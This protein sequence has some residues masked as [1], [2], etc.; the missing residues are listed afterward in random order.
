MT[1]SFFLFILALPFAAFA[2]GSD[3]QVEATI[4][5]HIANFNYEEPGVMTEKGNLFGS[6][7]QLLWNIQ[8]TFAM[9]VG[10]H[11]LFGNLTY[12][13]STFSG[14]PVT[15]ETEDW[16]L[17][18]QLLAHFRQPNFEVAF[19]VAR[20]VWF[21]DLVI[22]Y[23]RTTTYTYFPVI[24]KGKLDRFYTSLEYRIWGQGRNVSTLSDV[25]T[26]RSDVELTQDNGMGYA[27]EVGYEIPREKVSFRIFFAYDYWSVADSNVQ[28]DGVDFLF[29]P[30]NNTQTY[31]L[32]GG[33][34]F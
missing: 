13:G 33:I 10:G 31:L 27:I 18:G 5:W 23:T 17:Q 7:G 24:F 2:L 14:T 12:D 22:S 26:A 8:P 20:R 32:G 25:S 16:V 30:E 3:N 1:K 9:S 21:N 34:I 6:R 29:E 15:T 28:F 4:D 11:Y 19:G